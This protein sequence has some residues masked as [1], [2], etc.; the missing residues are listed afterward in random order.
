MQCARCDWSLKLCGGVSMVWLEVVNRKHTLSTTHHITLFFYVSLLL[1]L[2]ATKAGFGQRK[3]RAW[4][5][6]YKQLRWGL[7][8]YAGR[9][10]SVR[11]DINTLLQ[12]TLQCVTSGSSTCFSNALLTV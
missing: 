6:L 7:A 9:C 10:I 3:L 2:D 1:L 4:L 8:R 5:A 12:Q 11:K